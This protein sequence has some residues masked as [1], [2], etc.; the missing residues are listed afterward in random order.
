MRNILES[1]MQG[2]SFFT[3]A[4]ILLL[5][6]VI[7]LLGIMLGPLESQAAIGTTT[8]NWPA[9]PIYS[10]AGYPA[11]AITYNAVA[12]NNRLL[13]VGISSSTTQIAQAQPTVSYGGTPM[14]HAIGYSATATKQHS[15]LY[16]LPIGSAAVADTGK[17]INV[18]ISGG[19]SR[20]CTVNAA[21][22]IGV[23]QVTPVAA[24][25]PIRSS[26]NTTAST[27]VGP[28]T[29]VVNS[30][31]MGI[32]VLNAV[33]VSAKKGADLAA[34]APTITMATTGHIWNQVSASASGR[35]VGSLR[36]TFATTLNA[37][38]AT[39]TQHTSSTTTVN[40]TA[41][42][43]IK[44]V[45]GITVNNGSTVAGNKQVYINDGANSVNVVVDAFS[46]VADSAMTVSSITFTANADTTSS[47]VSGIK[48]WRKVGANLTAW[49]AG[50]VQV[51]GTATANG[52]AVTIS[53]LSEPVSPTVKNYIVTYDISSSATA[54]STNPLTGTIT[55][56]T[57]A[58]IALTDTAAYS[59]SIYIYPTT[60]IGNGSEPPTARLPIGSTPTR[61]DA[62]TLGHNGVSPTDDDPIS[63]VS[64]TLNPT[65]I[66]GDVSTSSKIALLE[67]VNEA[68]TRLGSVNAAVA[69]VWTIPVSGLAAVAGTPVTYFI[70]ITTA[71]SMDPGYYTFDGSITA[72]S[73]TKTSNKLI[74]ND[75]SSQT[76]NIDAEL[77]VGPSTLTAATGTA[78]GEIY[79]SGWDQAT[80]AHGGSLDSTPYIIVR[81]AEGGIDPDPYC[82]NGT[83]ITSNPLVTINTVSRTA[84]DKG[85]NTTT[86]PIYHYRVCAKDAQGNTSY[87][88]TAA[89]SPMLAADCDN[90]PIVALGVEDPLTHLPQDQ[91]IKS[92]GGEP[93]ILAI[94][95]R[96][97]GA[98][99][100]VEYTLTPVGESANAD[101]FNKTFPATVTL[102]RTAGPGATNLTSTNVPITINPKTGVEVSQ[103]ERYTFAVEVSASGHP[104]ATTL[105]ATGLL[106]DMPPIVHNASNMAK[107]QYGN[108]GTT[109]TCATCHSNNTTN[110]K[111]VYQIISTP[112]GRRNVVFTK[113]SSV[114][115]DSAGVH[116]N[117][118]RADKSKTDNVCAVCHHRTRQH[119]YSASKVEAN[120]PELGVGIVGPDGTDLYNADHH[121][122]RDCVRCH[123]HNTAF[124]SIY[125]VCGDCHGFK[126]T[127]YSPVDAYTMVKSPKRTGA[128]GIGPPSYGAH[129]R[130]NTAKITCSACHSI[131]NHGTNIDVWAGDTILEMGFLVNKDTFPGFN[132]ITSLVGGTFAGTQFLNSPYVWQGAPGTTVNLVEHFN[133]TCSTYCHGGWAGNSGSNTVPNWVGNGQA[134]CNTCHY[135]SGANPPQSGSHAKHAGNTGVG[136]GAACTKCHG[137]YTL[138]NYTGSAHVNGNVQWDLSAISA[139]ATYKG[140]TAGSTGEPAT[141]NSANYATCT[142]MYC[143]SNVQGA[144]GNGTGGPTFYAT[145]KWGDVTTCGSC[146]AEPNTTGSH[147]SHENE[148]VSFDCH[149]CHNTGGTTSPRNHANGK[150]EF[151]FIG[152][153]AN[154]KYGPG[155]G[156][157]SVSAGSG[158]KTCSSSNCHGLYTRAWGSPDSG[159]TMCDKCHGSATS[160]R[161]FYNTR[162]PDGTLSIYSAAIGVHD[163]HIQNPNSPRKATFAR[164]TS[165]TKGFKCWQCH[166]VPTG[167]F[168]PEHINT[169]R[170][171]EVLFGHQSS[172]ANYGVAKFSYYTSPSYSSGTCSAI[173]CHGAGMDSNNSSG[174]YTG[175]ASGIQRQNPV[176]DSPLLT[177]N[178]AADCVKCHAMPPPA[179]DSNYIHFEKTLATCKD[180]HVHLTNDG[181]AFNNKALHINGKIDGGCDKCHGYPPINNIIGDHEG[182]A[183][184]AQGA[185]RLGTAG[186]HNAHVLNPNIGK[187]CS[188]CHNSY[189]ATMPSNNLE[190]GFRAY[191][192]DISGTFTGYS[193]TGTHPNWV[194][195]NASTV[196]QEVT[197][198]ANVCSNLYCHGGGAANLSLPALGGGSKTNPNW[199]GGSAEVICGT[200]HGAD[201]TSVPSGGSHTKHSLATGGGPG[202]LCINCHMNSTNMTHV[203]GAVS[204][205]FDRSIPLIGA[206]ATYS[207]FSSGKIVG[208]APRNNGTDYQ[209]CNNFYCHSN[210]QGAGGVGAPTFYGSPKWGDNTS[211]HCGSCHLD[212]ATDA[213]GT[214]SHKKHANTG[215]TNMALSCG[216]CH[217][218]G[219][220]GSINHADNVIYLNFTSYVGGTYSNNA[221]AA[222][223]AA[224]YGTCS[225]TFCHGTAIS[226]AWGTPGPL[227]CYDCHSASADRLTSPSWSGRHATHYN[228]STP[229]SSY[230]ATLNRDLSNATKYRFNCT[231]CHDADS[232]K[233]SLK[234]YS[235]SAYARVFF[236]VTSVGTSA[237]RGK[238]VYGAA[239]GATDNGFKYT[240]GSCNT[241]Y[242]HS[243]GKKGL[244]LNQAL[245]WIT[246]KTGGSNCLYCHDGKSI[247]STA[248]KLSPRHDKHMNP[249][250][251]TMIGI[252]NTGFNCVDCHAQIITNPN[253]TSITN[254]TNHVTGMVDY[255]GAKAGKTFDAGTKVCSNVYCH[256]NGNPN[257]LVFVTMTGSKVWSGAGATGT[258]TTCNKCHG[259]STTTGYPDYANGGAS[260]ATSNLHA[261]HMAGMTDTKACA[262][263]HRKTGDTT[264]ID[265][266]RPY[267]TLHMTGVPNVYFYTSKIYIGT[268]ASVVTNGYQ[269]TCNQIVCHGQGAPV[270]G[271]KKTGSGSAGV[272]TCTKCHGSASSDYTAGFT[273]YSSPMVAPGYGSDG[274]DTSMT[275]KAPTDPRVGAHQRHLVSNA[276]TSPVKC[277]ECHLVVTAIR[278]GNHWNYSTAT[279][280]FNGRATANGHTTPSVLRTGGIRQCSNTNC[281]G[282]KSNSG[283]T[284]A[285]FWNVTGLVKEGA[286]TVASCN[287][288]HGF[289]P[290]TVG[291][292]GT[293]LTSDHTALADPTSFPV[294]TCTTCH[295]NM[296]NNGTTFAN[297]FVDK[298]LHVN[299]IINASGGH[300]YPYGGSVHKPGGTGNPLADAP[301]PYDNCR[302]C[303]DVTTQDATYDTSRGSAPICSECHLDYASFNGASPGCQDCHGADATGRPK[304][305]AAVGGNVFPNIS[306][307]HGKHVVVKGYACSECHNGGGSGTTSHGNSNATVKTRANVTVNSATGKFTWSYATLTCSSNSCHGDV[308]WGGRLT[309]ISCH[310]SASLVRTK[311]GGYTMAN[312]VAEFTGAS[313]G[314][315]KTKGFSVTS[316]DCIVCHLEGD[317]PSLSTTGKHG[318]G[319]VD[320]RDH[321]SATNDVAITDLGGAAITFKRFTTSFAAT[322]RTS[323]VVNTAVRDVVTRKF[324][325]GCH[326][327]GGSSNNTAGQGGIAAG[328]SKTKPFGST[329]GTVLDINSQFATTNSSRHPVLGPL[330][331]D[332]PTAARLAVPY[333]PTGTRGTSGTK[334]NG[335]II[336]CFDCHNTSALLTHRTV[337]A[338]GNAVT[339]RGTFGGASPTFCTACHLGYPGQGTDGHN[340]ATGYTTGSA[341]SATT[342]RMGTQLD[343]CNYCHASSQ[344]PARP[345]R[346]EDTHGTNSLPAGTKTGRWNLGTAQSVPVAFIRNI[347]NMTNHQ[348]KSVA[349]TGYSPQ[350]DM[351]SGEA[352]GGRAGSP[353]SPGGT[354]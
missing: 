318:D 88:A 40:S 83:D 267:S 115:S 65:I 162:G 64:V 271:D 259:R 347:N 234:P 245:T 217:Q 43:A 331:K 338:H 268:K 101:K 127:Q 226:P 6:S 237:R 34:N 158:Y 251:N 126:G 93:F 336:N 29:L 58:A 153:G 114:T 166:T 315:T 80:D 309:C 82:T 87:G 196:I 22:Y 168:T 189:T 7:A 75:S 135:A 221:R 203:D 176:W 131:T 90:I 291:S 274:T 325:L 110:I 57:P 70:R 323:T 38:S 236:G 303:H 147:L 44:P 262:D 51:G 286:L 212:M 265:K 179:P 292:G 346:A 296:T 231:H 53:G 62:F 314:H 172:I 214:G 215:S 102:G 10:A 218:D 72:I 76:L 300:A 69:G 177:G 112:I 227:P 171:A 293:A 167:P 206:D 91:I 178:G 341:F 264:S 27:A 28:F 321:G 84:V 104:T 199:E 289:P 45:V 191:N 67:V 116:S 200:C 78:P 73:H 275:K 1:A 169:A 81:G 12:G 130:H 252:G 56:I 209:T 344:S 5:W 220:D 238:Y 306:G 194:S 183:T 181:M 163:I 109:Y 223:S 324:C 122:S 120:D 92:T 243:D 352:C 89:A 322:S 3:K 316:S 117:D 9:T 33:D 250:N 61:L 60:T 133:N 260:T 278:A 208:L 140:E 228:Y 353:Y 106:N 63:S 59:S 269:V 298:S 23:D 343:T 95:Y 146:H 134:A 301:S 246:P 52:G 193:N 136:I 225:A 161:G 351:I 207:G 123:T 13:V 222:G 8:Q 350:C 239:Q 256:S 125:G 103:L 94:D 240:A 213:T 201:N 188:T 288:C 270:W 157:S 182:L 345:L 230:N 148:F 277:G 180:C 334:S 144:D 37:N 145:P 151:Q 50:D 24:G 175:L 21:V 128:L 186:A 219:G 74:E 174:A 307:S 99:P 242:C 342:Q 20:F 304:L 42:I 197:T 202:I 165:Y 36:T 261:G 141:D 290:K 339:L 4:G 241:S 281:H 326:K 154:T 132:S 273:N 121:N 25:N 19:T 319:N 244:P 247:T 253:N 299:G 156:F 311:A 305:N 160:P 152:L 149:V 26:N 86:G 282:G 285:P 192:N 143:H 54:L 108:W 2:M 185:L 164:F 14:T 107:I 279:L 349:G 159:L 330:N 79:L 55:A 32:S 96:D 224:G 257:A 129:R 266:F 348:P 294:T 47:R 333:K 173:W 119:Q 142:N 216:Y 190:L 255:S 198:G 118:Q 211:I 284:I 295:S 18:T 66:S 329:G 276:I 335:V 15:Y 308:V 100:N 332:Y 287:Q 248:S 113:I 155:A 137:T 30:G 310:D 39:Q 317:M 105:Q 71:A 327:S 328:G 184:P 337:S 35:I 150:I 302:G 17:A 85:L 210:V 97:V 68:G 313:W 48:I 111:G 11:A 138:D 254:K 77:P 46:M 340:S 354:Y 312:V 263:C 272:R 49:E 31:E 320:L 98:C 235:S 124:K 249:T 297:I 229:P 195:R 205:R 41:A 16:Y 170:P 232:T 204:W 187:L 233:H 258:I 280:S 139:T 283:A